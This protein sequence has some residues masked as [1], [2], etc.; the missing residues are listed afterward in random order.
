[1]AIALLI[2]VRDDG[3]EDLSS[4]DA[5]TFLGGLGHLCALVATD[6]MALQVIL[7]SRVPVIEGAFGQDR[8]V[9][10]HRVIGMVAIIV[11]IGHPLFRA[12]SRAVEEGT[13][14]LEAFVAFVR[15]HW[16]VALA[17]V[18]IVGLFVAIATSLNPLR[19]K[20]SFEVW[21]LL[22][23]NAY[24]AV[25]LALPHEIMTGRAFQESP[26]ATVYWIGFH[27]L[28]LWLLLRYR[29]FEPL[30]R[31]MRHQLAVDRVVPETPG[32]VSVYLRG[33]RLNAIDVRAGQFFQ[34]RFLDRAG[35]LRTNPFSLSAAPGATTWRITVKTAG[36]S[37]DRISSLLPGTWV[38]VEGPYGVLTE[39][40]RTRQRVAFF[41]SGVG[42]TPMRALAEEMAYEP[43]DAIL[44]YRTR[45]VDEALFRNEFARLERNRGLEV[46]YLD[47][48]RNRHRES[49]LPAA[50]GHLDD[51]Q[52]LRAVVPD[53]TTRDVFVCGGKQ[54]AATL[55]A[56]LSD[57]GVPRDAVHDESFD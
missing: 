31:S 46:V 37:G 51:V 13:S 42:V 29:L 56:A 33:R 55:R 12:S 45:S 41:A 17:L 2:F 28:A 18:G 24:L 57:A 3:L 6:L 38:A 35:W 8:I 54:W 5:A 7:M 9:R 20:L 49:W 50:A 40:A 10:R 19:R 48:P 34:W 21:H 43:G 15:E 25:F 39:R 4:G 53:I 26:A 32:H 30:V 16:D 1:M 36:D 47:G 23:L 27:L 52:A 14:W 22:H 44:V 11:L